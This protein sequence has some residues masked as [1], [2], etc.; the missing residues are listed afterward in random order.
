LN[1]SEIVSNRVPLNADAVNEASDR[2]KR[3]EAVLGP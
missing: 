3:L 1:L 2:L